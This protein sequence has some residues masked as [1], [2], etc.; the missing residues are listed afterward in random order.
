MPHSKV[1]QS[2]LAIASEDGA[3]VEQVN[4]PYDSS[5]VGIVRDFESRGY[6]VLDCIVEETPDDEKQIAKVRLKVRR[7]K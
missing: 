4:F 7:K 5:P 6:K 1:G 2:Y 3:L